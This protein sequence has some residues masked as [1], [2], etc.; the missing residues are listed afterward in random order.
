MR[1]KNEPRF[2]EKEN[3]P[4]NTTA[5]QTERIEVKI[6]S[7]NIDPASK[8][9][10]NQ[11]DL[12]SLSVEQKQN[13]HRVLLEES[14][15]FAQGD[16]DIGCA[17]GLRLPINLS[18]SCPVQTTY[19]A[20]PKPLYPEVKQYIEDLL[21]K[22]FITKSHSHYSSPVVCVRNKD[23]TLRLCIDYRQLN[24]KTI[25]DRLPLPRVKE[26]LESLGDNKWFS[27]LD[28]GK[29]YHQGFVKKEHRNRTAF[30]TPWGLYEWVR[31]PF[32][33][34]NVPA[35]FQRF[36]DQ[37]LDGLRNDVCTPYLDHVIVYSKDFD[38]HLADIQRVLR[39][40][41]ENGIKLKPSKCELFK[42]RVKYLG[43][44][45]SNDGYQIATSNVRA[46]NALR[47]CNPKTVGEVRRVLGLLNYYRKYVENFSKI[48]SPIFDLL[49]KWN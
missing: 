13:V 43:N 39:R 31:I 19:N 42:K 17:T 15:S 22:G 3:P 4:P 20:I 45:V 12:S 41:R 36:M 46:L 21:N 49:K 24:W 11:F 8:G 5:K 10:L 18:D 7:V 48:A 14:D 28:Q 26:T 1:L 2:D 34:S 44:I 47:Q 35:G 32:G 29:A 30:V 25:P 40:L 23:G 27:L 16:G 37:C 38:S 33:L 6:A 9:F